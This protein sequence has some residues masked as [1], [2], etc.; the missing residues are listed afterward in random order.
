M[1]IRSMRR[2]LGLHL[3]RVVSRPLGHEPSPPGRIDYRLMDERELLP[4]FE[5]PDLELFE[6]H[7]RSAFARGD[8]CVGALE[9]ELLVGYQWLAFGPTPHTDGVW[10]D[11]APEARYGYKQF[12]RPEY[13]GSRIAAA[14]SAYGD[15][16]CRRRGCS[17]TVA[18]I[19]LSNDASRRAAARVGAKTVGYAGYL[20]VFNTFIGVRSAGAKASGFRFIAPAQARVAAR[21]SRLPVASG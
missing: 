6:P 5:D 10:V 8:L 4:H 16:W 7:V 20:T 12:V 11:F 13:R 21:G 19:D 14:L 1:L 17:R 2:C 15:P 18:F 9:G 3:Y